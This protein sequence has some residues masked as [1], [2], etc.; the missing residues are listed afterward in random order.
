MQ[1]SHFL[2]LR[3]LQVTDSFNLSQGWAMCQYLPV[4]E[5]EFLPTW[6]LDEILQTPAD[7]DYG[8]FLE[9]DLAYPHEI[10]DLL[11]D[12]PPAPVK[13]R[14]SQLSPFQREMIAQNIR[15]SHPEWTNEKI[16]E[17]INKTKSNEK[18]IASL[19]DKKK[20]ICHYRLLQK[21][22]EL[23]MQVFFVVVHTT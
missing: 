22:V 16:E 6:Q 2:C 19:E 11:N 5:F 3:F 1:L 13:T 12:F 21:Y 14:P 15:A 18:L 4:G 9:V 23:G 8:Y 20:Y 17:E 7:A 10:H